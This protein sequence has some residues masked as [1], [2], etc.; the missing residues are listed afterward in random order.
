MELYQENPQFQFAKSLCEVL[1]ERGFIAYLA[2]GCVRDLL[3][4]VTPRDFDIATNATPDEV[5]KIFPRTVAVGKSFGVINVLSENGELEVEVASFR[6]D[7]D[8]VD[9]RRP[10]GIVFSS[11]QEDAKRR[12]LTVNALFYDLKAKKIIDYVD[13]QKDIAQKLIRTVGEPEKRFQEDHLRILRAV[14][15]VS[16]LGFQIEPSTMLAISQLKS[17][18]KTVSGER[19][20][21]EL[22]KLFE[23]KDVSKALT[24]FWQSRLLQELMDIDIAL[25]PPEKV[26]ARRQ[27]K[28]EEDLWFRFFLWIY[29]GSEALGFQKLIIKDF[30]N[31]CDQWKFSRKL[32]QKTLTS[33]YWMLHNSFLKKTSLGEL[34]ELSFEEE[35][36]R[37]W[38]E[39]DLF[40]ASAAEKELLARLKLRKKDL[41]M[42]KP[43]PL[44]FAKDLLSIVKGP[45]LGKALSW[46]YWRQ[47]EGKAETAD[48]LI[49]MW[50]IS[51]ALSS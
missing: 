27:V 15:F 48:E 6:T 4:K 47:L 16:Q 5:E 11:P 2:G 22:L 8:Y 37:A 49:K 23:G 35:N 33:M 24:L 25:I 12:D 36:M 39:Y 46:C 44:V 20:Q 17:L 43:E 21:D 34:L 30:E 28:S 45:E 3:L 32:K 40:Y 7:G 42:A 51:H 41:G 26:F 1:T 14:R 13:G 31:L 19:I 29:Q 38:E 9:G 10:Q 50:K 18:I